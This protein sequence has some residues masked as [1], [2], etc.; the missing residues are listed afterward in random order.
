LTP[1]TLSMRTRGFPLFSHDE[2]TELSLDV[3]SVVEELRRH[4]TAFLFTESMNGI[5]SDV[6]LFLRKSRSITWCS[7]SIYWSDFDYAVP[8]VSKMNIEE[9]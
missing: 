3:D 5:K 2:E 6:Q 8:L 9:D 1:T 4:I 7:S